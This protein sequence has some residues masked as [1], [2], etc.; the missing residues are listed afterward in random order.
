MTR[1][2]SHDRSGPRIHERP[3]GIGCENRAGANLSI[4]TFSAP[5]AASDIP[6][7]SRGKSALRQTPK[8]Q[9][10][11]RISKPETATICIAR[12]WRPQKFGQSRRPIID[13]IAPASINSAA[14]KAAT[15][16]SPNPT[17]AHRGTRPHHAKRYCPR[18][19]KPLRFPVVRLNCIARGLVHGVLPI[20]DSDAAGR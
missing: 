2:R 9:R 13:E 18:N 19:S 6:G 5:P 10:R 11:T 16:L 15:G 3:R 7:G 12:D 1:K 17:A 4:L 20:W 14:R 8:A